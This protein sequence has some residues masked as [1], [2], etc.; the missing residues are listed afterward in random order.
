M[1]IMF[2]KYLYFQN[3][4]S[5]ICVCEMLEAIIFYYVDSHTLNKAINKIS[6]EDILK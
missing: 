4:E 2:F 5:Q 3:I 1:N 6:V